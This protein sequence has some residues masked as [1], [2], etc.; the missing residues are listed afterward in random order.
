METVETLP[1]SILSGNYT[2][3]YWKD[4]PINSVM[5][6]YRERQ[7]GRDVAAARQGVADKAVAGREEKFQA[8]RNLE[9]DK[10]IARV[11]REIKDMEEQLALL[12]LTGSSAATASDTLDGTN[13]DLQ[14]RSIDTPETE[15]SNWLKTYNKDL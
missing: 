8:N 6:A 14:D 13:P 3:S 1:M 11:E 12:K 10:Q 2:Q 9:L 15:Q 4:S 7:P 5:E